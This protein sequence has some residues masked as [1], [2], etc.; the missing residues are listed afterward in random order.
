MCPSG[1]ALKHPA[2]DLLLQYATQGCP[3]KTGKNWTREEMQAAIDRGNHPMEPEVM[4]QLTQEAQDK[5]KSGQARIVL[6]DDIK[7]NPPPATKISP[8]AAVP[9]KSRGWRAILDLSFRLRLEAGKYLASVNEGSEKTAPGA[10]IDQIGHVL[11]RI[12]HAFAQ[13]P[14]DARIFMAK[15]DVKDGFWRMVVEAGEEWNF[16]YVLP[17]PPGEPVQ[18][19]VPTSLQMGWIESPPYFCAASETARDVADDYV[20]APLGSLPNHKFQEHTEGHPLFQALPPTASVETMVSYMVEVYVDDFISLA[21]PRLK[22]NCG[23]CR[24][25]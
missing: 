19:V 3:A 22:T 7:D 12:I 20:N 10:S 6:W 24:R 11:Q 1:L 17:T 5:V 15:W 9:H 21:I 8:L 14:D 4:A 2:A 25:R 23:T 16:C 18:L 13:A